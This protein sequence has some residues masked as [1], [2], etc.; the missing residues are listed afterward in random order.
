LVV[1][2]RRLTQN[3]QLAG[4][5]THMV[6]HNELERLRKLWGGAPPG[7]LGVMADAAASAPHN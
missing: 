1:A 2:Q 5:R 6:Y 7:S 4:A 3:P